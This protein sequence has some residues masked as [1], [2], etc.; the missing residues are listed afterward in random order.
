MDF[1]EENVDQ[2]EK[3][4]KSFLDDIN[5][6]LEANRDIKHLNNIDRQIF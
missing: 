1:I 6:K 5:N 2:Q 4:L 3:L